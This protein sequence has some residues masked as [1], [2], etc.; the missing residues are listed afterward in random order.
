MADI[1]DIA[2]R[3]CDGLGGCRE[4]TS[5]LRWLDRRRGIWFSDFW[6]RLRFVA[7]C[8]NYLPA[9]PAQLN[10]EVSQ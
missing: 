8:S 5:C 1:L 10:S 4:R 7:S 3:R 2:E 9:A 6:R